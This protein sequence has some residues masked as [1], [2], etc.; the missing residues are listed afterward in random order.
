MYLLGRGGPQNDV[1]GYAWL[2]IAVGQGYACAEK[3]KELVAKRM[4]R[5]GI[6]RAQELARE[7]WEDYVLPF[8]D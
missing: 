4:T 7:Y 3:F 6:A 2:N 1:Q 5:E 8:R